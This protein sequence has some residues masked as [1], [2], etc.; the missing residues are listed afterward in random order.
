MKI[1]IITPYFYPEN[2]KINDLVLELESRGHELTIL[3]GQPN[4]PKGNIFDGYSNWS[5]WTGRF[6]KS[7]VIRVPIFARGSG[8]FLRL[9]LSYLVFVFSASTIGLARLGF[10]RFDM[11]FV[12]ATSPITSALPAILNKFITGTPVAIWIQDLWPDAVL[13]VGAIRKKW[14]YNFIGRIVTFI[15]RRSDLL[16]VQSPSF[17]KSVLRWGGANSKIRYLPNW[18]EDQFITQS[19]TLRKQEDNCFK[20]LFA[21]NIGRA[22]GIETIVLAAEKNRSHLDLQ[23]H[24]YGEGAHSEWLKN[25]IIKKSLSANIFYHG[26]KS[27]DEMPKIY[28]DHDAFL[29]TLKKDPGL[30][31]VLPS[32][33]QTYLSY[34]RPLLVSADGET[35][36]TVLRASAGLV[37]AAEDATGLAKNALLMSALSR[38]KRIEYANNGREF[39]LQEFSKT[40]IVSNLEKYLKEEVEK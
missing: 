2:F 35:S 30:S 18:A 31:A 26:K 7:K 13:A 22:Q 19:V 34:G 6:S 29:V 5:N 4:Y 14:I 3:T 23:W 24:I 8:S 21:G 25:E 20:I 11:S 10:S 16:L 36:D 39:Y 27:I 12:F 37:S 32:K 17:K 38:E 28:A 1:L 33:T 15:Y 9:A 40:K